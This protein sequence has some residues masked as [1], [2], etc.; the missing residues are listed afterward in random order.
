MIRFLSTLSLLAIVLVPGKAFA[1]VDPRAPNWDR[2]MA[3]HAAEA[4]ESLDALAGLSRLLRVQDEGTLGQRL[5]AIIGG[6]LSSQ[7]ARDY[8]LYRFAVNLADAPQTQAWMIDR[9]A[10]VE[11]S[12]FVSHPDH[13][14]TGVPLFNIRA[15]AEGARG[16]VARRDARN[17]A[18][19]LLIEAPQDWIAAYLSAGSAERKGFTDAL[20]EA[21]DES[22]KQILDMAIDVFP[23]DPKITPI[24]G[25]AALLIGDADSLHSVVI[26][27]GGSELA[28][29][30]EAATSSLDSQAVLTLLEVAI[31]QAPP[32][33]AA[34]AIAQ[35]YPALSGHPVARAML[36]EVLGDR[37]LGASAALALAQSDDPVLMASLQEIARTDQGLAARRA[38]LALQT[39]HTAGRMGQ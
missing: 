23:G 32:V 11:P 17:M 39:I 36:L 16:A 20:M 19:S 33:N 13:A 28:P 3:M 18:D 34:L 25:R 29:I 4:P 38:S 22:L 9:L 2:Q 37:D 6:S 31:S 30:L 15:A 24:A 1:Q 27:G 5:E 12:V 26:H 8:V 21:E 10:A 14:R 35:L 7:P